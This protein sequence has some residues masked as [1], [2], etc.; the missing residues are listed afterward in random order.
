MAEGEGQCK[1][2]SGKGEETEI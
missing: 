1:G 2:G